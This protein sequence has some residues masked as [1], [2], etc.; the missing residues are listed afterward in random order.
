M[1]SVDVKTDPTVSVS[2]PKTLYSLKD[3][4]TK[5]YAW[6]PDGRLMVILQ[7]ESE[8]SSRIDLV[9]NFAEEIRARMGAA[10]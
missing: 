7:G 10:K 2:L 3:L 5:N 1:V 8:L 9:V 6:G 4:K